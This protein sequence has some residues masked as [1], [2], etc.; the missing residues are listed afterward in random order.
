MKLKNLLVLALIAFL[1]S[2][3]Y[4][5]EENPEMHI[6][7]GLKILDE[8]SRR[9]LD[10]DYIGN[11]ESAFDNLIKNPAVEIDP[12]LAQQLQNVLD[13]AIINY[14]IKGLSAALSTPNGDIWKGVSG[15][16]H[17][18]V[19][20]TTDMLFG[21]ASITKT[22][23][24]TIIM[25]LYEADSLELNDSLHKW[26]PPFDN[27]D[28]TITIRQLL[29][30]T[31]GIY[32]STDHPDYIDSVFVPGSRI[33]TSEEILETFVLAPNF[34]PGTNYEYS[35]TNFRLLGM[36]IEEITGNEIVSELHNRITTPLG[37]NSTFLFPYEGYEGVRS[38]VWY[39][40]EGG[41]TVDVTHLVDTTAFSAAWTSGG[42]LSNAE[43]LVKWSK[44]LYEGDILNDTTLALMKV[45]GPYSNG[46]YGLGT[47]INYLYSQ[48]IYGHSGNYIYRSK[49]W[50]VPFDS[51]SISVLS[52]QQL[53]SITGV[54]NQLYFAYKDFIAS[55]PCLPDGITFTTQAEID[56][57]QTNYP[58][59]TEIEGD[60]TI[61]G[62]DITN[63]N[64]LS[65]LTSIEGDLSIG[66]YDFEFG[67][68]GNPNLIN[69]TGLEG[70]SIIGGDLS[71]FDNTTLLNCTGLDN[72]TSIGGDLLINLNYALTSI[73]AL[74]NM[75]S[76]GGD[77]WIGQ[78]SSLTNLSGLEGLS[79]IE[80]TLSFGY[81]LGGGNSGLTSLTG[82]EN[83]TSIEGNLKITKCHVL[84]SLLGLNNVTSIGGTLEI[85]YNNAITNLS[86]LDNV[87][88]IGGYVT[89]YGNDALTNLTGLGNLTFIGEN[90]LLGGMGGSNPVLTSLAGLENLTSIGGGIMIFNHE[91]L[92][93]LMTLNNVTSI[94]GDLWIIGN[95]LLTSL[96][97]L[98]NIVA[99]SIDN[100]KIYSNASLSVC[101]VQSI[102]YYLVSPNGT[103]EI[104]DNA[105]GCNSQSQVEDAC[106]TS[107][108]EIIVT[109]NYS[110]YPNPVTD[111]AT[112]SSEEITSFELYDMMGALI[113][114]QN[115]NKVD[116][117]NL[118]QGIY[119]VIGSDKYNYPLF[120]GKIIKE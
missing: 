2:S 6:F 103:V 61:S 46:Y 22:F 119:F 87:D 33:W 8:P 73:L 50:Y 56:I 20:I 60:V 110:I 100:L 7:S 93:S 23:T 112:F 72:V 58:Y 47:A 94:G 91:S 113:I 85:G 63:L 79:S 10:S 49:L 68:T 118:K 55:Q 53:P 92:V 34:P 36:I 48:P 108:E 65:V 62:D 109:E 74:S 21:I 16:S 117:S 84:N 32:N 11:Q 107:T 37:L 66:F 27:I 29:N 83:V 13:E 64:G 105:I 70:I 101:E 25:Q 88:S 77:L 39:P 44:G 102:C 41:D 1:F 89:I 51:I 86:G 80:G 82:L 98:D 18:T 19:E 69:L 90:F 116:M 67:Y 30:H 14:N 120:K 28:S 35:N 97:G 42:L 99:G 78:N 111:I 15:I 24:A 3:L 104:Y 115:D 71:I 81:G 114:R 54:W 57:F 5:Q 26:L 4:A 12:D 38:H 59:C 17:D 96:T 45:P 106:I 52:N 9:P 40:Y 43:D 95:D 76:L 75:T 31:S